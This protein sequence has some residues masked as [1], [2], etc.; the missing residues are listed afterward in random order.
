MNAP[1]ACI[2][3][4]D[5]EPDLRTLYELTLLRE[6]YR[7]ETA[8]SVQEAREQIK[9]NRFDVVIADMRLPDG[10]GMELL[11]DLREQQR[12][13]R[14]VVMTAYGSAENAVEALRCG[15]FDYLTKP[16]DLRQF[17]SV[18]ASAVQGTGG[19]VPVRRSGPSHG[20][21]PSAS[22]E[23]PPAA[24]A[25]AAL[26]RLIGASQAMCNVR[27]RVAKIARGMAPV[28]I[29]GESGTGKELVAQALHA[30]SQRADGPLIAVNCGAIP[31][32]LLEAEFF[33]ARK[34]SYTGAFQDRDGYF[35]A[36]RGGTLF[37]DE[38]G[39]L[40]LVMQ[41]KLLRA[42][43]ERSVRSLGSTQEETVDVR[44]VS[45]THRDLAADVRAGRF[46]Q[47]LYYRLNV[48][49]IVIPPLRERREDLPALCN[50]LLQR[51]AQ[52]SGMPLPALTERALNAI[53]AHPLRGNV[54]ELENLLHRAVALSDGQELQVDWPT[55]KA[56]GATPDLPARTSQSQDPLARNNAGST[57][58]LPSDLQAWLDQ[59]ERE[60][61]VRAL[62]ESRFNRSATAVRLGISMRQIGYRIKR[63]NIAVPNDQEPPEPHGG[64]D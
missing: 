50:A 48:I 53:A 19:V 18:V 4:V 42:I 56:S 57:V 41:S 37:L 3:V 47:D 13:E 15:A 33:G 55:A 64:I 63:L 58:P 44:I 21:Q 5:D 46:R 2:L 60:I 34:G 22:I 14:C 32:N 49:E 52:E 16:V 45:A 10:F 54:R 30:S 20:R 62:R 40:P 26:E 36:A 1:T 38:I 35:Q 43:Q 59:H 29:H 11:Q 12:R 9:A 28:L 7:V 25:G 17:R 51:I 6:G 24:G 31:E 23:P 39:D 8:A 61:L 27:Q